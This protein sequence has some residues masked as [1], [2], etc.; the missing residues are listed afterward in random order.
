MALGNVKHLFR[1]EELPTWVVQSVICACTCLGGT[2]LHNYCSSDV[3][4]ID[5]GLNGG[6]EEWEEL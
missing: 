5:A 2:L 4:G 1:T 3:I 6:K